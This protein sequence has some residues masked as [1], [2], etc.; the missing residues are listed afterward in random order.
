LDTYNRW[1]PSA[2]IRVPLDPKLQVHLGYFGVFTEGREIDRS[3][4]FLSPG[5]HYNFTPNL[6]L[7]L[8]I[9]WGLTPDAAHFFVNTG[10]GWRF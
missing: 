7:G 4:A 6:E 1:A 5:M 3:R 10:F 2:V 9:G 8:R